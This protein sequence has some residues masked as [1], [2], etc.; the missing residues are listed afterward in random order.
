MHT[1][2]EDSYDRAWEEFVHQI[3]PQIYRNIMAMNF[4]AP[5]K[6]QVGSSFKEKNQINFCF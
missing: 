1:T 5:T 3:H 2:L 4:K 6:V